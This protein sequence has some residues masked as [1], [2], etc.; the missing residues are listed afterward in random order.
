M[1]FRSCLTA[2]LLG[3]TAC[4]TPGGSDDSFV[5]AN[6]TIID[7]T[8]GPRT[9]GS[10]RVR[11]DRIVDVGA[12]TPARGERV[13]DAGGMVLA[14]GFIDTHSHATGDLRDDT[15]ARGAVS[16]GITT[17]VGGQDGGSRLPLAEYFAEL[18]QQPAPLNIAS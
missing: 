14:P 11:S 3:A 9:T 7:G 1:S 16:Q 2:I 12:V 17:I 10:V 4:A 5:V 15:T 6:A 18:E 8:G 13:V